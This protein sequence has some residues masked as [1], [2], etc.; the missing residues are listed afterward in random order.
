MG[1]PLR[2]PLVASS[3][4]L[5]RDIDNIKKM[6][7]FGAAA[8]VLHSL[9]EEQLREEAEELDDRLNQ[10]TNSFAEALS[11]F[12]R[13]ET[14]HLGPDEYLTHIEKAKE[15]VQ[16]PIIASLNGA[17]V[18]G[19]TEYAKRIQE[20]GADALELNIYSTPTDPDLAG[21]NVEESYLEVL[22]AVRDV[23]S[24]PV[25]VKL[26]PFFSNMA[27]MAKRLDE[28][29]ANA[30][31]LFNRFYQ[32]DI[33][34]EELE[35]HP[36]VLWSTP[37]AQRLPMRWIAI[38]AGRIEADLAATSGIYTTEDVIKM[39]MAG[40]KVTMLYSSL[41]RHGISHLRTLEAE[42]ADWLRAHDYQ[43]VEEVVGSMSQKKIKDPSAFER[44][45]FVKAIHSSPS[46][47]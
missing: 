34:I 26:S 28:A 16:I 19:W 45:Q 7:E 24:I 44:A 14:F 42:L 10:G 18:G 35:V 17:S 3:S 9:F 4:P 29:G 22:K 47:P 46:A 5:S 40:A 11:Y 27:N 30:L 43:S 1:L 12:P 37:F 8:V 33:D 38:L 31:V 13:M 25:G 36:K 41:A 32:P 15:A 2:S 39:L 20:A 6:E 21:T 23:V